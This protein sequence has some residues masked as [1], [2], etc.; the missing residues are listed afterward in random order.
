M[1]W[2][3]DLGVQTFSFFTYS[4]GNFK[5]TNGE[6]ELW[7][8]FAWEKLEFLINKCDLI[9]RRQI[10]NKSLGNFDLL[11]DDVRDQVYRFMETTKDNTG[12]VWNGCFPYSADEEMVMACNKALDLLHKDP[13][14][15]VNFD[16]L[17]Y[18]FDDL[19]VDMVLRTA[20]RR[21]LSQFFNWQVCTSDAQFEYVRMLFPH[22]SFW[23]FVPLLLRYQLEQWWNT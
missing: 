13:E 5:R 20:G 10:K 19:P 8:R 15:Y 18:T 2:I 3:Y 21:C 11:P 7:M 12:P 4:S 14:A 1:D 17:L 9:K 23:D 6:A 16:G 22:F